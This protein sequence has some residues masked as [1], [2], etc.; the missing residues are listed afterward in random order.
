MRTGVS[1]AAVALAHGLNATLLRKWV[2][3]SERKGTPSQA[4]AAAEVPA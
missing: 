1:M 2:T 4:V 3:A